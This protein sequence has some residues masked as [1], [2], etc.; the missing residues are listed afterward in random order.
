M[1]IEAIRNGGFLWAASWATR[2]FI[3]N[4]VRKMQN[5]KPFPIGSDKE[6]ALNF[7]HKEDTQTFIKS[8]V[9][10]AIGVIGLITG[11]G[12]VVEGNSESASLLLST[13]MAHIS[14]GVIYALNRRRVIKNE[15]NRLNENEKARKKFT[16]KK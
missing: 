16:R 4:S 10:I 7:K 5:K 6:I 1:Q 9:P 11:F 8:I 14:E 15:L 2:T 3:A 13:G 12:Q